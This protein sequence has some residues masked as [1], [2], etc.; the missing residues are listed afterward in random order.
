V[1]I[2]LADGFLVENVPAEI[3]AG[4]VEKQLWRHGNKQ[5]QTIGQI[6]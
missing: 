5:R 1:G 6:D 4:D 3:E 2:T